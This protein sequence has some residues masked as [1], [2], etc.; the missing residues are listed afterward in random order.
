MLQRREERLGARVKLPPTVDGLPAALKQDLL[1]SVPKASSISSPLRPVSGTNRPVISGGQPVVEPPDSAPPDD[2][3]QPAPTSGPLPKLRHGIMGV[4]WGTLTL[5]AGLC[6]FALIFNLSIRERG[7]V[8]ASVKLPEGAEGFKVFREES[9]FYFYD[10]KRNFDRPNSE[11]DPL[12]AQLFEAA[13]EQ[14]GTRA[15]LC[16]QE[17]ERCRQAKAVIR[18]TQMVYIRRHNVPR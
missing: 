9:N 15:W 12:G 6:L 4:S 14:G 5:C 7:I 1:A 11:L 8:A 17:D 3:A 10:P 2:Q 16:F 13:R 18:G